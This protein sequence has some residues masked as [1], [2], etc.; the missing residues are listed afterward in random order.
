MI[1]VVLI[2]SLIGLGA[3]IYVATP[4][5]RAGRM[6]AL[7]CAALIALGALGAYVVN[8]Q[9]DMPGSPYAS[10]M[11]QISSA[12]PETL[13]AAEQEERLRAAIRDNPQDVAAMTLLGR[14]LARTDR[15]LEG[16]GLFERALRIE[17]TA[18][19]YADFGQA[20]VN[21]NDGTITDRARRA[22]ERAQALEPDLPEAA[23]F[24]GVA[25]YQS[26]DR[27][28]AAARWA[29]MVAMLPPGDGFREQIAA[30]AADLLSRPSGGPQGDPEAGGGPDLGDD[31]DPATRIA[32]MVDGLE[33]RLA[34]EPEDFSGWLTLARARAMLE[35]PAGAEAALQA[36]RDRFQ[37][38][39][40]KLAMIAALSRALQLEESDA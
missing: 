4:L 22:F 23:F 31:V 1:A 3:A 10:R 25:D 26:G 11:A 24:L 7:A 36:A 12:D 18:R 32:A 8:G 17:P 39:P 27:G 19:L 28:A 35:Q 5:A 30:R 13:T 9:P 33:R 14:F 34:D 6:V 38:E 2:C 37:S 16:I 15:E 21:L 20:L 40:G 29:G